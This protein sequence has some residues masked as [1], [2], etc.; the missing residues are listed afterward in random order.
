M[1]PKQIKIDYQKIEEYWRG[2]FL[3]ISDQIKD[4]PLKYLYDNLI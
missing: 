4:A 1:D 3:T 2:L